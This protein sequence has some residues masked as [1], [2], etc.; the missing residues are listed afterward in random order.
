MIFKRSDGTLAEHPITRGRSANERVDS[1][2][3]FTGSAFRVDKGSEPLLIFGPGIV[4]F[5]PTNFWM[6]DTNSPR[7]SV[8]GWCQGAVLRVGKGRLAVFGEAAMFSA[9]VEGP[10]R[11]PFGMNTPAA[12]QNPQF[13]LN[14]LHWL[15]GLLDK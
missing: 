4:S 14:L 1:L 6:F 9:Q 13:I 11:E 5:T 3:T 15:S 12:K 7:I 8:A 10:K 2:A